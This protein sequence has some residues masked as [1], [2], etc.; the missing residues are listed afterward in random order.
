MTA[1]RAPGCDDAT[2]E[3][4][5]DQSWPSTMVPFVSFQS[6][7]LEGN[8]T[9]SSVRDTM[10][11]PTN[12]DCCQ[13]YIQPT[14]QGANGTG[15]GLGSTIGACVATTYLGVCSYLAPTAADAGIGYNILEAPPCTTAQGIQHL[16]TV[17]AP[18]FLLSDD[19][20]PIHSENRGISSIFLFPDTVFS[21]ISSAIWPQRN[22]PR[23]PSLC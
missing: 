15:S 23:G 11:D 2:V 3:Q 4:E 1:R 5:E 13:A 14:Y 16:L 19:S 10:F 17:S 22:I 18:S 21:A 6:A 8:L 9:P 20:A 12:W 7:G